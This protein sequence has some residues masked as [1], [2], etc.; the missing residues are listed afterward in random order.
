M[1]AGL[2]DPFVVF[3]T[4]PKAYIRLDSDFRFTFVN[5]AAVALLGQ[6]PAE[7]MG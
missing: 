6:T 4:I 5:R 1:G 3:D 7:L 2:G